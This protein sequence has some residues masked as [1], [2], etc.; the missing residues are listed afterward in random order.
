[1]LDSESTIQNAVNEVG[2]VATGELLKTF[3]TEGEDILFGTV[4]MVSKGLVNKCYQSPY[5]E[6]EIERHIYQTSAGGS[7][8]CPLEREARIIL[9]STP[10]FASQVS[11]KMSEMAATHVKKDF[12]VS[13]NRKV[14]TAF[15]QRLA[16]AVSTVVQIKEET[17]SYHVP[18]IKEAEITTVSIGLDGTCMLMCE[19]AYRQAMVGTIALYDAEG[20][21]QH[22]TYIA[23]A[24]EYGKEKFKERLT[25][26]IKQTKELYPTALKIGLA[27][28]ARDNWEFLEK[29]TD[30]QT[31]DFYHATEY[32]TDV[33]ES[34]FFSSIE[35]KVWLNDRCHQLKHTPGA[36]GSL[37]AE[38]EGFQ[39][40]KISDEVSSSLSLINNQEI[41]KLEDQ[42][43]DISITT[44]LE[45]QIINEAEHELRFKNAKQWQEKKKK[46]LAAAITYFRNNNEKSRMNYSESVAANHPIGSG[47]TE[48]ACKTI[49]KQRLCQSGMRWK[50]KGA[51]VILSLRALVHSTGRWEQFWQKV[52]QYGFPIAA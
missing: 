22:T 40:D 23:A 10:R 25:R 20:E 34:V 14:A 42:P 18:D 38:M 16:E 51:G 31:L 19:G 24:P 26:E 12:A 30:K 5:G 48:A 33:A 52:N 7:T 50:D 32:L 11:H 45:N 6:V 35:R 49:V 46:S 9:T 41:K 1:M 15:I 28:G 47:I 17:W 36:A 13:N 39:S 27:D 2:T 44:I 3:D 37:L 21:R 8:F 4:K 29:H 43:S